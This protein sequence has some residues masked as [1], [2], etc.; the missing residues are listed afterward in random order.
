MF[1]QAVAVLP[2]TDP[3]A[4]IA[5]YTQALG[6][7]VDWRGQDANGGVFAQISRDQSRLYLQQSA[8]TA[9]V[10][11]YVYVDDVDR[12]YAEL[13]RKSVPVDTLPVN[14]SWGNREM[15]LSDPDGNRIYICMSLQA[16]G[17]APRN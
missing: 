11:V 1:K 12:C 9:P 5:F 14:R 10:S 15:L 6:F 4:G 7:S 8:A 16:A 17:P 2:V 3:E 13:L